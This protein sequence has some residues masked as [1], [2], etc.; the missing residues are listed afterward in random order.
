MFL[1]FVTTRIDK[2]SHKSQGVFAA[3]YA[4][5]DSGDLTRDEWEH[6]REMTIRFNANL[7]T[8]PK[9]FDSRRAIFWFKSSAKEN[10]RRVWELVHVLRQHGHHV[11][12]H[13][14]RK[15]GNIVWQDDF[16]AAAF[17]SALDGRIT[18]Q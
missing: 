1:R 10:I 4:L 14:C 5:L 6:L 3:S 2:D 8:P 7:P 17:P 16:Q 18:I 12:V 15:L 13:K 9:T 11:E